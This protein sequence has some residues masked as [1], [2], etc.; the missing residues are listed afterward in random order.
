MFGNPDVPDETLAAQWEKTVFARA[1]AL[2]LEADVRA[3]LGETEARE[4][5]E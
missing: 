5:G 1:Q 4:R 3:A 2:A